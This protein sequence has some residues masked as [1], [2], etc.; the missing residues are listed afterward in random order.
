M[1]PRAVAPRAKAATNP[2]VIKYDVYF[3]LGDSPAI[4][5]SNCGLA[6]TTFVTTVTGGTGKI[7]VEIPGLQKETNYRINVV[8]R[9]EHDVTTLFQD[10][11]VR[12]AAEPGDG[13]GD[14]GL[15]INLL[16]GVGI[17]LFI[18]IV[19]T[20]VY[21][22]VRNRKLTKELDVEM[23]DVPKSAVLK[24]VRGPQG[25]A[26]GPKKY[27]RLLEDDDDED[28]VGTTYDPPEV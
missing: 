18:I 7:Q 3:A 21:L 9:D 24:A 2:G 23:H 27:S 1:A 4:M 26:E 5:Y 25:R 11:P 15:P 19:S 16:L 13:G 6:R 10:R 20:I 12:T 28:G 8:A 17:P 14:G 22:C